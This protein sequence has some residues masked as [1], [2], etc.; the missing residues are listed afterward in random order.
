MGAT[1]A[2]SGLGVL[3][4]VIAA[5]GYSPTSVGKN[6]ALIS[7]MT[8]IANLS[9]LNLDSGFNRF[10]PTAGPRTARLVGVG[11]SVACAIALVAGCVYVLGISIWSPDLTNLVS[12]GGF[13]L[14]FIAATG[15]WVIF[16]IQ[17]AVLT[18]LGRADWVLVENAL[19]GVVKIVALVL[20]AT[21]LP[22]TG[23]F[24][25]WTLP[26]LL[27][28]VPLNL[29]VFRKLLPKHMRAEDTRVEPV[30][31]RDVGR[32][33][34]PDYVASI[35]WT[36]TTSLMPLIV[37]ALAGAEASAFFYLSFTV[38]Y[39]LYFLSRN[40]GMSLVT[41]GAR[42]PDRLYEF[43][44]RTLA[45]CARVV[46][47]LSIVVALASPI[48]LRVFGEEYQEGAQ[49]LLPLLVLSAIPYTVIATFTA[50]AR[51][52]RRMRELLLVTA[53]MSVLVT[54]LSV[55]MLELY[56]LTGLG[57]G[58]LAGL[59]IVAAFLLATE[60]RAVWLPRVPLHRVRR[61]GRRR[62]QVAVAAPDV[63]GWVLVGPS[64]EDSDGG[65]ARVRGEADPEFAQL[66]YARTNRGARNLARH[67][68]ALQRIQ[69]IPNLNGWAEQAPVTLD[70][71]LVSG[72]PWLVETWIQGEDARRVADD[73]PPGHM[74]LA[75]A[76]SITGLHERTSEQSIVA[77]ARLHRWV[78]AP[79]ELLRQ[80]EAGPLR[81]AADHAALDRLQRDLHEALEGR[82]L[83]TAFVHGDFWLGN[84]IADPGT[85]RVAGIID[86]ERADPRGLPVLDAMT[87]LLADRV[88]AQRRELGRV[89]R[90]RLREDDGDP[91]EAAV[92]A[93][94]PGAG[95]IP[96]RLAV[97]LAWLHHAA[98]NI[99]KRAHYRSSTVWLTTNVHH[100]LEVL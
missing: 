25:A 60:L 8:F 30:G 64:K 56:G 18:G 15:L 54:V 82:V 11:Y 34:G 22:T 29:L 90:D 1:I 7:A 92:M 72:R 74:L 53:S 73:L 91:V 31:A 48:I 21:L 45:Q 63:A 49:F 46:V 78:D 61:P 43:A 50:A 41:E 4:W 67:D 59:C 33:I 84:V 88:A 14:V 28:V 39:A 9:H 16:Q 3:Y 98:A 93:T 69:A 97:L 52:Q 86:W 83:T 5:H 47:P 36:A 27:F 87:L 65:T 55:V 20:L 2:T 17:D 77:E 51:V 100:V 58:W 6:A 75:A 38:A 66:R 71:G 19:Y 76:R 85:G 99:E 89:V 79:I 80:A 42:T 32:Y 68:A 81:A 10:V 23:I 26:L 35:F 70:R 37:L 94:V 24:A 96:D 62:A 12:G 95:E 40:L 13:A 44:L 57:A